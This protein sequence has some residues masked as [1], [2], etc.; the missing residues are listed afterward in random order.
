MAESCPS[1]YLA[2]AR[3]LFYFKGILSSL[4]SHG[5]ARREGKIAYCPNKKNVIA[6]N[7]TSQY[8]I[9]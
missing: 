9:V 3:L 8:F 1:L 4:L 2:F 6:L 7:I 5:A